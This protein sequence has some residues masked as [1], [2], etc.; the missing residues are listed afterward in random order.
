LATASLDG[1]VRLWDARPLDDKEGPEVR[2]LT[3]TRIVSAVAF[4]AD[5]QYLASGTLDGVVKIWSVPLGQQLRVLPGQTFFI[6][7]LA[8]S[9]DGKRLV[10]SSVDQTTRVWE[11]TTGKQL[12]ALDGFPAMDIDF[13]RDGNNLIGVVENTARI[14]D[15]TTGAPVQQV[16]ADRVVSHGLALAPGG[17]RFATVG[18]TPRVRIWDINQILVG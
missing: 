4:S 16:V 2:T 13:T 17:K 6:A 15:A 5:G 9:P 10:S 1:T 8:F 14:W 3:D 7:A 18:W 11:T 12:L